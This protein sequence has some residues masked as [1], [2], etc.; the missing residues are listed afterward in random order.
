[1]SFFGILEVEIETL[2]GAVLCDTAVIDSVECIG[3]D[4]VTIYRLII[5]KLCEP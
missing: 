5:Q 2:N 4:Y 3:M 1:M